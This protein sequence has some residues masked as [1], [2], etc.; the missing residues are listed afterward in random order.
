MKT[1]TL[2]PVL[3]AYVQ[4]GN[5][6]LRH[7]GEKWNI[8]PGPMADNPWSKFLPAEVLI[9]A[10]NGCGD[11]LYIQ[12][13]NSGHH[14][15]SSTVHVFWHEEQSSE[16]F[17][18]SIDKLVNTAPPKATESKAIYYFGGA[19]DVRLGDEVSARD[20]LIRK[21]GR[22]VYVPG[23]SKKNW[24]MEH[25]GLSWIGIKFKGGTF[26]GAFINPKSNEIKKSVRFIKRNDVN[27]EE[28]CPDEEL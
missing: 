19:T 16:I 20:L 15:N 17:V 21:S 25:D 27:V 7:E 5:S 8:E 9:I 6:T 11:Y 1:D 12:K 10:S 18:D 24:N 14:S 28:L 3:Q 23:K 22:V 2:P 4:K 13:D 26:S